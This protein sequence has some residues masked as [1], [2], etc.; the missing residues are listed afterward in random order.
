VRTIV[1]FVGRSPRLPGRRTI[2]CLSATVALSLALTG[3]SLGGDDDSS[4][5]PVTSVGTAETA[6]TA[7][8][9]P[10]TTAPRT[11][12]G[13]GAPRQVA[14]PPTAAQQAAADDQARVKNLD[15][16]PGGLTRL[17][18]ATGATGGY[19][20]W[21]VQTANHLVDM[22]L[23]PADQ[24]ISW[25]GCS[26]E[27]SGAIDRCGG[28]VVPPSTILVAGHVSSRVRSVDVV[29][30]SGA[31]RPAVVGAGG[32]LYVDEDADPKDAA[33]PGTPVT[34]EAYDGEGKLLARAPLGG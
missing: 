28:A 8:P 31:R 6:S 32:W 13:P 17:V 9:P 24:G 30:R 23:G 15:P 34:A 26:R 18:A 16:A 21:S 33:A 29:V 3:C 1:E 7:A 10:A 11:T 5:A 22:V 19:S 20:L 25:D 2:A 12:T 14:A 27:F 4:P